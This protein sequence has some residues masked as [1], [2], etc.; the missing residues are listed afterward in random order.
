[1]QI[2][3]LMER[4]WSHL[5]YLPNLRSIG[6]RKGI[7]LALEEGVNKASSE[8][9]TGRGTGMV[10]WRAHRGRRTGTCSVKPERHS[11]ESAGAL[12]LAHLSE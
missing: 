7:S 1:M 3:E 10:W 6:V 5:S 8:L 2:G 4:R 11:M 12:L 9:Q